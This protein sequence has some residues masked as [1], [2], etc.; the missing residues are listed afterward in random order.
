MKIEF[1]NKETI[2][3]VM[4]DTWLKPLYLTAYK[5]LQHVDLSFSDVNNPYSSLDWAQQFIDLGNRLGLDID[6]DLV[7]AQD[8]DYFNT[9]HTYFIDHHPHDTGEWQT[10]HR[11]LHLSEK[12]SPQERFANLSHVSAAWPLRQPYPTDYNYSDEVVSLKA[13]EVVLKWAELGKTPYQ[14]WLDAEPDDLG[15]VIKLTKPRQYINFDMS[16]T[17]TDKNLIPNSDFT[18]YNSWWKKY[19]D[20]WCKAHNVKSWPLKNNFSVIPLGNIA[21]ISKFEELL[22]QDILPKRIKL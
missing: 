22:L 21:D 10:F 5:H 13:G 20:N 17:L 15:S 14:Y 12:N 11:L 18:K 3:I 19:E 7:H 6:E 1:Q 4:D 2:E 9:L 8:C 16:V